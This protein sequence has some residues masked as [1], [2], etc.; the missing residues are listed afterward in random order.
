MHRKLILGA[1]VACASLVMAAPA[2][3]V[4]FQLTFDHMVMDTPATPNVQVVSP[5]GQPLTIVADVNPS[6]GQ[7]TVQPSDWHFPVY[8][9]S[10]PVPGTV[11][12]ELKSPASGQWDPTSGTLIFNADFLAK[13][14]VQGYGDCTK[15]TGPLS[16]STSTTV[17]LAGVKFPAT[18]T[19]VVTGNG[20]FGAGWSSLA[21]GTG[22]ACSVVDPAVQ[23]KGGLW[24]SRGISP[25]PP[26]V[27]LKASAPKSV[28]AGSKATIKV[29]VSVSGADDKNPIRVCLAAPKG[30]SP[31]SSCTT[32]KSGLAEGKSKT[33]SF[34][35]KTSKKKTGKFT[36]KVK[37]SGTGVKTVTKKV[38]LKVK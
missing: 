38:T 19:G 29:K 4:P 26:S 20:A 17:P 31:K 16:L 28:K 34:K 22:T 5:K 8:T 18:T 33:V 14:T 27:S 25:V 15:D 35:V 24:I 10:Q 32:I 21:A 12:I 6:T 2:G 7:F 13:I 1:A 23:G 36:L 37:A 9:M 3:A 11:D 30:L